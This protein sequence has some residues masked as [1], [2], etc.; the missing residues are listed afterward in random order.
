[1]RGVIDL[2]DVQTLVFDEQGS[3]GATVSTATRELA[4]YSNV[5]LV[6]DFCERGGIY[7]FLEN[8]TISGS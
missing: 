1:M 8:V 2:N 6:R 3:E 5:S 7:C 4:A